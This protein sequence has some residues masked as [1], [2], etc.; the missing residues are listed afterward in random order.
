MIFI[1]YLTPNA[2]MASSFKFWDVTPS[3]SFDGEIVICGSSALL[4]LKSR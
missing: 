4:S 2:D 3:P 1:N